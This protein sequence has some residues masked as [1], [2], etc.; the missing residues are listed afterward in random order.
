[1]TVMQIISVMGPPGPGEIG[2]E[3]GVWQA[4]VLDASGGAVVI[5]SS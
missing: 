4:D 5:R 2:W 3:P 1:M